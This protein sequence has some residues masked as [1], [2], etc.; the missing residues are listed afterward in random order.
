MR[1]QIQ[2]LHIDQ[3][4]TNFSLKYT[5]DA[6]VGSKLFT[7]LPVKKESDKYF[8]YG[9]QDFKRYNTKAS[10]RSRAVEMDW[11]VSAEPAY[12]LTEYKIAGLI[13]QREIENADV[14]LN[15]ELDTTA[16][17]TNAILLDLEAEQASIATNPANYASGQ[18]EALSGG[19]KWSDYTNSNPVAKVDAMREVIRKNIGGK[20]PN[21]MIVSS[22]V[23]KVLKMHPVIRDIV[24]YT[25]LGKGNKENLAEIFEVEQYIVAGAT[26]DAQPENISETRMTNYVWGDCVI[27]AYVA[28]SIGVRSLTF[29]LTFRKADGRKVLVEELKDPEGKRIIV[30]DMFDVKIVCPYAGYL[31]TSVI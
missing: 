2:D 24:K 8:V 10:A 11:T 31:L 13:T 15:P 28:P 23:H 19:N 29:G 18:A 20:E 26:Y 27:L 30:K 3:A 5:N 6:F 4:L 9:R 14:P 16:I 22:S 17:L 7:E 25:S 12:N 21:V 1:P